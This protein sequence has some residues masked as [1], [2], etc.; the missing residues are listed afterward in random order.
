MDVRDLSRSVQD[1][2][3]AAAA[4]GDEPTRRAA[5]LLGTALDPA[6]RLALQDAIVQVAAE[7][8]AEIAPGRVDLALRGPELEVRVVPPASAASPV[9]ALPVVPPAPPTPPVPPA[10]PFPTDGATDDVTGGAT[11]D[12][13]PVGEEPSGEAARVSFR[14]PQQLKE[15]LERAAAEEGLS[16]NAYLVRVLGA[17]L[18][19]AAPGG[20]GAF[21]AG[22]QDPFAAGRAGQSG[23]DGWNGIAGRVQGW[24]L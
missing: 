3:A 11:D 23:A 14:P 16:L 15:R 9:S 19:G 17:H 8:S 13:T 22:P 2:L 10:P 5:H 21:S 18:D 7:V 1:Q 4:V 12:A 6:L 24:F 20:S